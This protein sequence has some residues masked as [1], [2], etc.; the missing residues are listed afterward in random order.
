MISDPKLKTMKTILLVVMLSVLSFKLNAQQLP[1]K[2]VSFNVN[3]N[4]QQTKVNLTWTTD[5]ELNVSH[6]VIERST[7]GQ[8]FS[9]HVTVF[10]NVN[11]GIKNEY[12]FSD[13]LNSLTSVV[14]YYRLR[15]VNKNG[16]FQL[17]KIRFIRLNKKTENTITILTYPNPVTNELKVTIPANWQNKKVNYE[18]FRVNGQSVKNIENVNSSQIENINVSDLQPGMYF[19]RVSCEGQIAQQKLIKN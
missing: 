4:H 14:I 15:T 2:L 13:S 17:S 16:S 19:V 5:E 1:A 11:T 9:K 12:I 18:L 7:D 6:F 8:H 10:A 3:L